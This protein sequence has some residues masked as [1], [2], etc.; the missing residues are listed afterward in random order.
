MAVDDTSLIDLMNKLDPKPAQTDNDQLQPIVAKMES[1][2]STIPPHIATNLLELLRRVETKGMEA[3]AWVEAYQFVQR[4]APK[5]SGVQ[6][7]GLPAK[8]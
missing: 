6:F 7:G 4:Y 5:Q 1:T 3:V 2:P 8:G